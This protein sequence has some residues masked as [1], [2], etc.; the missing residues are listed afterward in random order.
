MNPIKPHLEARLERLRSLIEQGIIPGQL[1]SIELEQ[2]IGR[3][4][5]LKYILRLLQD[6]DNP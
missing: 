2:T 6:E 4:K 5:E 1:D 3:I